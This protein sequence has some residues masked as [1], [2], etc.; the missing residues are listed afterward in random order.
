MNEDTRNAL[1]TWLKFDTWYRSHPLDERRF[2]DFVLAAWREH[3]GIW[4]ETLI[5][6]TMMREAKALHT[7]FDHDEMVRELTKRRKDGT[8]ILDFLS[9]TKAV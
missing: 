5:F 2:Y 9:H 1:M 3:G 4:N 8:L 6:E 7:G